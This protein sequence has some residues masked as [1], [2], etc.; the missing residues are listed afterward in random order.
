MEYDYALQHLFNQI[1]TFGTKVTHRYNQ[2]ITCDN[3]N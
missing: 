2:K 1:F 3:G